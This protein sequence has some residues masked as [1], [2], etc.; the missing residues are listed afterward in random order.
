MHAPV[1]KQ[2]ALVCESVR[3][4]LGMGQFLHHS[5]SGCQFRETSRH[6]HFDKDGVLRLIQDQWNSEFFLVH[7]AFDQLRSNKELE[8][9]LDLLSSDLLKLSIVQGV[10]WLLLLLWVLVG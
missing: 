7:C 5:H 3:I 6:A 9:L 4:Y 8:E 1:R 10:H 2:G